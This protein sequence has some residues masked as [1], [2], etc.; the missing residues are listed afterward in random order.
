MFVFSKFSV[1]MG[2]ACNI[3]RL[4]YRIHVLIMRDLQKLIIGKEAHMRIKSRVRPTIV[5]RPPIS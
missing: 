3:Y 5:P 4:Y 1:S 2:N